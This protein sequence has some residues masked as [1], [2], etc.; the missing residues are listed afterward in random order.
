MSQPGVCLPCKNVF[1]LSSD[2]D[3]SQHIQPGHSHSQD[4]PNCVVSQVSLTAVSALSWSRELPTQISE[5]HL[6][7]P[8]IPDML[9]GENKFILAK[10]EVKFLI[11]IVMGE[12]YK[13][14]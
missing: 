6:D 8:L 5:L 14:E 2:C 11:T 1:F 4:N 10:Q 7:L 9:K 12:D 13:R 3:K